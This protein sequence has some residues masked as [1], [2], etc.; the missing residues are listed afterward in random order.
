VRTASIGKSS[1]E[2][3]VCVAND[4]VHLKLI[5]NEA[6]IEDD[7][8][9]FHPEYTHQLFG[10]SENIFGY[11]KLRVNCYYSAQALKL[12]VS[13]S[14]AEKIKPAE[15]VEVEADDVLS[16]LKE[17]LELQ[18]NLYTENLDEFS[19]WL[20]K[21][22]FFRPYGV[23]LHEF[24]EKQSTFEIYHV[25]NEH[26]EFIKEHHEQMQHFLLWFIDGAS[27]IDT[28]DN[29]WDFFVIYERPNER[30]AYFV[31]Y[32]TAYRY[33]AYPANT[34]P[35]ISQVVILPPFQRRN[36]GVH[37]LNAMY[38]HYCAQSNVIDIT[39][40]DPADNFC[41]LRNYVDCLACSKLPSFE[42]SSLRKG[43]R[44]ELAKEARDKLRINQRQARKVYEI[45]KLR[46]V[47][48]HNQ[49]EYRDYRLEVKRRLSAPL[50]K[51]RKKS[52][53]P[54]SKDLEQTPKE[55]VIEE[56]TAVYAELEKEYKSTIDRLNSVV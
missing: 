23:K 2:E 38:R 47:N 26:T 49:E 27:Y 44:I 29:R 52:R 16:T 15:G 45:L 37:L 50:L 34:R 22:D 3:F 25:T 46:C 51:N 4:A 17:K 13:V 20:S 32:A 39:V 6:D 30:E 21:D 43:W 54:D 12:Y 41:Q 55:L 18:T 28:E 11:K 7:R 48:E 10:D 56:L 33:Y 31:G 36:I 24:E 42:E 9:V 53:M 19:K 14:Y 40:E 35:R 5:R 8:H 1:L